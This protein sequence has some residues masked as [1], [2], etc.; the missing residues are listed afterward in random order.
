MPWLRLDDLTADHPKV[1]EL[2]HRGDRWR[3]IELLLLCARYRTGGHVTAGM[4]RSCDIGPK[5][6]D[7]LVKLHLLDVDG[8]EWN[9]HDWHIYNPPADPTGRERQAR[10]RANHP[11]PPRVT[12]ATP[13]R[14]ETAQPS[15]IEPERNAL[16]VTDEVL[17]PLPQPLTTVE[18]GPQLGAP[19]TTRPEIDDDRTAALA[20]L[21]ALAGDAPS[22][23]SGGP[24]G[25]DEGD[26]AA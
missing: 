3:W 4:L 11:R 6:R 17:P 5:L 21:R 1:L 25:A 15:G 26:Q 24:D 14:N 20:R 9:A 19:D 23:P 18:S 13:P 8:D 10:W 12:P 2:A 22:W 7:Q 16:P